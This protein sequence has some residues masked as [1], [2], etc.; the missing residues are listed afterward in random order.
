MSN[1]TYSYPPPPPVTPEDVAAVVAGTNEDHTI[2]RRFLMMHSHIDRRDFAK[3][4]KALDRECGAL[5]GPPTNAT[6]KRTLREWLAAGHDFHIHGLPPDFY[7][8]PSE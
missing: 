6:E 1:G 2:V 4:A 3:I 5:G 7:R 8:L